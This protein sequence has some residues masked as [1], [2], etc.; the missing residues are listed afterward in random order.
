MKIIDAEFTV[1][2]GP[3]T[4]PKVSWLRIIL[5][6]RAVWVIGGMTLFVAMTEGW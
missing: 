2:N 6:Q 4:P 5:M 1:V 3:E